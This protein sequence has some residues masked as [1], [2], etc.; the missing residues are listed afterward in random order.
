MT[1]PDRVFSLRNP[2]LWAA[3]GGTA[4]VAL[5]AALAGFIW[6]PSVQAANLPGNLWQSICTAAGV[7][8]AAP[9][10]RPIEGGA[11]TSKVILTTRTLEAPS[12]VSIGRGATIAHQCAICHGVRRGDQVNTPDLAGQFAPAIYKQL[13]DFRSGARV[14]AVMTPQVANLTDQDVRDLAAYFAYLPPAVANGFNPAPDIVA[15]GAPMRNIPPCGACHG[16]IAVKPGA[17][18]LEGES[19][20]YIRDQLRA[21]ADGARRN[22]INGQMRNIARQM[23]PAEIE[24]SAIYFS[25]AQKDVDAR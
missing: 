19:A 4:A 16:G 11:A 25:S 15:A 12:A 8:R 10:E 2:W 20:V 22:D 9:A 6:F 13:Q 3:G 7:T 18:R 23:T 21:F 1:P 24:A 5:I 14:S 17:P